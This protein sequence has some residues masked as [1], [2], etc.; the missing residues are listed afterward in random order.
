MVESGKER[1]QDS[2]ID[3]SLSQ[4][5]GNYVDEILPAGIIEAQEHYQHISNEHQTSTSA[6]KVGQFSPARHHNSG[7]ETTEGRRKR[8]DSQ[9]SARLGWTFKQDDLEKKG[10]CEEELQVTSQLFPR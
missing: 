1:E 8:R 4:I 6:H 2:R 5:G 3:D 9:A 10:N 7:D